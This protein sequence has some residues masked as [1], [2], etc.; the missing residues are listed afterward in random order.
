MNFLLLH[1]RK[2]KRAKNT[3]PTFFCLVRKKSLSDLFASTKR[4]EA[5]SEKIQRANM[6]GMDSIKITYQKDDC[7]CEGQR[8][9]CANQVL[10]SNGVR[11]YVFADRVRTL[12]SKGRDFKHRN[13]SML[14]LLTVEK[15]FYYAYLKS[16]SE[17]FQIL[18]M[19]S[20]G[21]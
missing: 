1:I 18:L 4:L 21:G 16:F 11:P 9:T 15:P 7:V 3:L 19:T 6:S 2:K 5:V 20:T 17:H 13:Q 12:L 14:A 8:L 10:V